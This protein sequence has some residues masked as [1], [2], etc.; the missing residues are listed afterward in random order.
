MSGNEYKLKIVHIVLEFHVFAVSP[1][2]SDQIRYVSENV[3][4]LSVYEYAI[5]IYGG[6]VPLEVKTL[7]NKN[8]KKMKFIVDTRVYSLY[9]IRALMRNNGARNRNFGL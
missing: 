2:Y 5:L 7:I 3:D 9:Y 6:S 1:L 4:S 8:V